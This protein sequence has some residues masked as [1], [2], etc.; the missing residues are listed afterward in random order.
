[1]TF[2]SIEQLLALVQDKPA[3]EIGLSVATSND[4]AE[5]AR[6]INRAV[7]HA[8][9]QMAQNPELRQAKGEDELTIELVS[10]LNMMDIEAGHDTK[11]GGHVDIRIKGKRDY[12]WLAE[13]KKHKQDYAWLM[14]GFQQLNTRY[15]TGLAGQDK[16]GFIVY[17]DHA[18]IDRTMSK[19]RDHL[20]EQKIE[21]MSFSNCE[22]NDLSFQSTHPHD[23]TGRPLEVRHIALSIYFDPKDRI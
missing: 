5:W 3:L 6:N 2:Q 12:H 21:G 4:Y 18:R 15:T 20:E 11:V 22:L 8:L 9:R 23:R 17:S 1:M 16:G 14:Q 13:A 7:D 19:W 10:L